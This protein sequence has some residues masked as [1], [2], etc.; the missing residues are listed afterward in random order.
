[1]I[2]RPAP[3]RRGAPR[4]RR[5]PDAAV[6]GRRRDAP[7]PPPT[8]RPT[9]A[10]RERREAATSPGVSLAKA[11][12]ARPS[13]NAK[14]IVPG[15]ARSSTKS[16]PR[17]RSSSYWKLRYHVSRGRTRRWSR[18]SR[19]ALRRMGASRCDGRRRAPRNRTRHSRAW[20]HAYRA[21]RLNGRTTS[22]A[23]IG[24]ETDH[25]IATSGAP[26]CTTTSCVSSTSSASAYRHVGHGVLVNSTS[27]APSPG[28]VTSGA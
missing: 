3:H 13:R 21:P 5:P 20:R 10:A 4:R 8:P 1:M 14:R 6:C 23:S 28:A 11:R 9:G 15:D 12:T 7:A 22:V 19:R 25:E 18:R 26:C 16:S 27:G 2:V 17:A 24:A